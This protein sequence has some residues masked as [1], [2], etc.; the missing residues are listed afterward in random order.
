MTAGLSRA[1]IARA[2]PAGSRRIT[3]Q[4]EA[5]RAGLAC[6][7]LAGVRADFREHLR[8]WWM[9]HVNHA[10]WGGPGRPPR[11]T[12]EP[13]R[14][15][16]CQLAGRPGPD[17]RRRPMSV[18]TY[19]ACRR[20]WEARGYIAIVRPGWT[21]DLAPGALRT[22]DDHNIRQAYVLC[23]PRSHRP[24][25]SRPPARTVTRPL[26]QSRRDL[27]KF[28]AREQPDQGPSRA[29]KAGALRPA[30]LRRGPLDRLTD[31]WWAHL[32]A[33]FAS[34][35]AA[36]LVWAIDHLPGGR[37]HRTRTASIRHPAGWLRWRLSHWLQADGT[38][39]PSPSQQRA[40]AARHHRAYLA[41]R[42]RL[43]PLASRAAAL[44]RMYH[45]DRADDAPAPG[46][47][48]LRPRH[49]LARQE[50]RAP[51]PGHAAAPRRGTG[52]PAWWTSAVAAAVRA[53]T[54]QQ[55][56]DV[57]PERAGVQDSPSVTRYIG[58]GPAAWSG[59]W[60]GQSAEVREMRNFGKP[61]RRVCAGSSVGRYSQATC[62]RQAS[63]S[64]PLTGSQ[65]WT[66]M[67]QPPGRTRGPRYPSGRRACA[68]VSVRLAAWPAVGVT[69]GPG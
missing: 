33:P 47:R 68:A 25:P 53:V 24:A 40:D 18:S 32:T 69:A 21:P 57:R 42:E 6:P 66:G 19:K 52:L 37:Q 60:T 49:A 56:D 7:D 20:W 27:D 62:K 63:G 45:Y 31:G 26:S 13:T 35:T 67:R 17:G 38:S 1:E 8:D 34:W 4:R 28:P 5:L 22:G 30:A 44:R 16:V 59:S 58:P 54:E 64:N 43:V 14:A 65:F 12:T 46:S 2:V 36:D 29:R 51:R 50:Q 41:G 61:R 15:R 11:G 9:I 55:A 10:S 3:A 23:T 39:L 48:S